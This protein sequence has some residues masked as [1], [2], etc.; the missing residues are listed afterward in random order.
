MDL[1]LGEDIANIK[2]PRPPVNKITTFDSYLDFWRRST[3]TDT[4]LRGIL[5]GGFFSLAT[6]WEMRGNSIVIYLDMLHGMKTQ[7][8][9]GNELR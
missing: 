6:A 2:I 7:P 4:D 3:F 5:P 9:R 1:F 8:R